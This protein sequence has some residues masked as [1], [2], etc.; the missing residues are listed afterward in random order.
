MS[1]YK[2]EQG[3]WIAEG[4]FLGRRYIIEGG[5]WNEA[6]HSAVNHMRGLTD[7]TSKAS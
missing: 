6:F 4:S 1:I 3:Y 5:S 7:I 2:T